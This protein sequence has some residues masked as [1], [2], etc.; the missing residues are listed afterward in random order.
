M[1]AALG[2]L[3]EGQDKYGLHKNIIRNN[4]VSRYWAIIFPYGQGKSAKRK[5]LAQD[6]ASF[7]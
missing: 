6:P 7:F 2:S 5:E 3:D 1:Y 4:N